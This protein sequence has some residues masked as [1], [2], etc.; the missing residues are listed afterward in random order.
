MHGFL[1]MNIVVSFTEFFSMCSIPVKTVNFKHDLVWIEHSCTLTILQ[2]ALFSFGWVW[3]SFADASFFATFFSE[4]IAGLSIWKKRRSPPSEFVAHI[5][6]D[7]FGESSSKAASPTVSWVARTRNVDFF[8]E[9]WK[10][11]LGSTSWKLEPSE[12]AGI[13][14]MPCGLSHAGR[15]NWVNY[16]NSVLFH[17]DPFLPR[18]SSHHH[19]DPDCHQKI[20]HHHPRPNHN[21]GHCD[22]RHHQFC[23]II[24]IQTGVTYASVLLKRLTH[25]I[26]TID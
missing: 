6:V 9:W 23:F 19:Y 24:T 14:R 3:W 17:H 16:L 20:H 12:I 15:V 11:F 21:P 7:L 25:F 2:H 13:C 10:G 8:Q 18:R 1:K 5:A 4:R 26:L 22:C